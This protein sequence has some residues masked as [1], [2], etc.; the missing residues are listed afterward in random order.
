MDQILK[1][2]KLGSASARRRK[3][4]ER[5][6]AMQQDEERRTRIL[7]YGYSSEEDESSDDEGNT[8]SP[9]PDAH[10]DQ[11]RSTSR[12]SNMSQHYSNKSTS[13][14]CVDAS[15]PLLPSTLP[16][17]PY[18]PELNI[19]SPLSP[20]FH[21]CQ[22]ESL[23]PREEEAPSP[24]EP[25]TPVEIATP[26]LYSIPRARPSMI[27]IKPSPSQITFKALHRPLS[28]P[29][30][31]LIPRRS[32]NRVSTMSLKTTSSRREP[33]TILLPSLSEHA[34]DVVRS[35]ARDI[36]SRRP[37]TISVKSESA[38]Q[39]QLP[40]Y[41][42]FPRR[43]KV[44]SSRRIDRPM[45][46]EHR[47]HLTPA[48]TSPKVVSARRNFSF[49]IVS[50]NPELTKPASPPAEMHAKK[51]SS[52]LRQRRSS[53]GLALRNA[54]APFRSKAS[55]SRPSTSNSAESAESKDDIDI[56][57]F[58]LPPPS[59]LLQQSFRSETKSPITNSSANSRLRRV[60]TTVGL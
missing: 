45:D 41:D 19:P 33:P 4:Q 37:V 15:P 27:S 43:S 16:C 26:I 6:I 1:A 28:M 51:S 60:R 53:I 22:I 38:L 20:D 55:V 58:P 2:H 44:A 49:P 14:H 24:T 32:D 35:S 7:L 46:N 9:I 23:F 50:R 40:T 59:P 21:Y 30:P 47:T 13:E 11:H 52:T 8:Y 29:H 18:I 39:Q 17:K 5:E 31:P 56:S 10:V 48:M 36:G 57:A 3:M 25:E 34:S 12:L 54:S 42:V